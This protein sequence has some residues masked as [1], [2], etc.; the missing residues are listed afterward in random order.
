LSSGETHRK[1]SIELTT[2]GSKSS[3][4]KLTNNDSKIK[5][6]TTPS[7]DNIVFN[8]KAYEI[9][10]KEKVERPVA[11]KDVSPINKEAN[12]FKK[13]PSSDKKEEE[14]IIAKPFSPQNS[15]D[16]KEPIKNFLMVPESKGN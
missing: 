13:T 9:N 11:S 1:Q 8:K 16:V 14:Y 2:D 3:E 10:S 6:I 5:I 7:K 4:S 15:K 12:M